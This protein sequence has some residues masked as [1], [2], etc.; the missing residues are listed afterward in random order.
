MSDNKLSDFLII[1]ST[2]PTLIKIYF[3]QLNSIQLN[4]PKLIRLLTGQLLCSQVSMVYGQVQVHCW[5]LSGTP[6]WSFL[7]SQILSYYKV[8]NF[9]FYIL[10]HKLNDWIKFFKIQNYFPPHV[11]DHVSIAPLNLNFGELECIPFTSGVR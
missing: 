6:T 11:L 3:Y 9:I 1:K 2:S 5:W 10:F 4:S 7:S 8:F